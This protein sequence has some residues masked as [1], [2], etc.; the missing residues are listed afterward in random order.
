MVRAGQLAFLN[1]M[2]AVAY[3]SESDLLAACRRGDF[4]A[5]ER[6]YEEHAPRL[7]SVAYHIQ[8]GSGGC[9]WR[10][11]DQNG[12]IEILKGRQ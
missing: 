8:I 7:K 12:D 1:S 2:R 9:E 4:R 10:L 11:T 5:F 3:P 6:L